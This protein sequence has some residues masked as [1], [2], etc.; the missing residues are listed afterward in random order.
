MRY[1]IMRIPV[2]ATIAVAAI[3]G[4]SPNDNPSKVNSSSTSPL[5]IEHSAVLGTYPRLIAKRIKSKETEI[6]SMGAPVS[7]GDKGFRIVEDQFHELDWNDSA[8]K[9]SIAVEHSGDR[10]LK[11][12][13]SPNSNVN[14]AKIVAVLRK[15]GNKIGSATTAVVWRSKPLETEQALFLLRSYIRGDSN[16][17]SLVNWEHE[18]GKSA[19]KVE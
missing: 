12:T 2:I 10:S 16:F 5:P 14:Q 15:P 19:V 13:V 11:I 17:E 8:S 6:I 4:C 18:D 7:A 1:V 3:A 9:P